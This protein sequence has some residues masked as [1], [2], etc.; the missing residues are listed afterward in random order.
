[1]VGG[2]IAFGYNY[3]CD[4]K[5]TQEQ[6]VRVAMGKITNRGSFIRVFFA[7]FNNDGKPEVVAANK[8]GENPDITKAPLNNIS[9]YLLP[10]NPLEGNKW[11]ELVLTQ[12]RI[13]INSQ[14][15]DLDLDGDM[16]IVGWLVGW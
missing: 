11:E 16:D 9:I 5:L 1:M 12:V 15:I 2:T 10:D 7:D 6:A 4:L 8:G 3:D 14:P 13:P